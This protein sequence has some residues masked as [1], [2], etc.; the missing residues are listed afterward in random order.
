[1]AFF[2]PFTYRCT[3]FHLQLQGRSAISA[4]LCS[5]NWIPSFTK[6]EQV[7]N[8]Y[9]QPHTAGYECI[10]TKNDNLF[11]ID[12]ILKGENKNDYNGNTYSVSKEVQRAYTTAL[13][14]EKG[15]SYKNF[16]NLNL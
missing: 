6:K 1:M 8:Y 7:I 14:R 11:S 16:A 10:I 2:R 13:A 9:M 5:P 4:R 12:N 15:A 3:I